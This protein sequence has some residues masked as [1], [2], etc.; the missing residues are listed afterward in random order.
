M[1]VLSAGSMALP[2][3]TLDARGI[4][5]QFATN[6]LQHFQLTGRRFLMLRSRTAA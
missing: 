5:L 3:R 6:H 1:L 4:E 2:E